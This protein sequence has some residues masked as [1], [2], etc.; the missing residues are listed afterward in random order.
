MEQTPCATHGRFS[1]GSVLTQA[2]AVIGTDSIFTS[3][4][5]KALVQHPRL[6]DAPIGT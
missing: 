3:G 1:P 4:E 5:V 2:E 6:S